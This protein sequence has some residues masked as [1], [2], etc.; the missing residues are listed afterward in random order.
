MATP[1]AAKKVWWK[2]IL[3]NFLI[4][5]IQR[6]NISIRKNNSWGQS[7]LIASV[8]D[9]MRR[10][11][12]LKRQVFHS[13]RKT[14]DICH[15]RAWL[16]ETMQAWMQRILKPVML[17]KMTTML[18]ITY[19][20]KHKTAKRHSPFVIVMKE[21]DSLKILLPYSHINFFTYFIIQWIQT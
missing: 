3:Y 20:K 11:F 2:Q 19:S 15:E 8:K 5:K 17:K 13:H 4:H 1:L 16:N 14:F 7:Y 12:L 6:L 10:S 9:K 18:E 21:A